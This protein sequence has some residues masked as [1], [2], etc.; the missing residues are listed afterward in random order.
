[1]IILFAVSIALT[2][3]GVPS[4][5][6][7]D[8]C[9][10]HGHHCLTPFLPRPVED[11]ETVRARFGPH[12]FTPP[13]DPQLNDT[14]DWYIWDLGGYPTATKKP[15]T[16]RGVGDHVYVVVEDSQWNVNIDQADVDRIVDHVDHISVGRFPNMGIWD[17]NTSNFGDPPNFD[18]LDRIFFLYYKFDISADGYFWIYDQYPDGSQP[19]ASNEADVIYLATDS[20]APAS[21]YM[22]AVGAHEFE[23]M[24]HFNTDQNE[25]SWVDEG[26]GE[27]AMW[28]F[29]HPDQISGFNTKPDNSL[30]NFGGNWGDYIQTYLW[31]LY[32]YEQFGG[33]PI[34]WEVCHNP[35]NGMAG[36]QQ[37]LV[38]QGYPDT[39]EDIFGNWSAANFLDEPEIYQGQYGYLGDELPNFTSF[40]THKSYPA[41]GTGSVQDWATDY[42]RLLDLNS[43]IPL[44]GF[45]GQDNHEFRVKLLAIDSV[46]PTLVKEMI[47]DAGSNGTVVF[48][49]AQA[50]EQVEISIASVTTFGT[51]SY[52]YSVDVEPMSIPVP[53]GRVAGPDQPVITQ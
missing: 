53:A 44:I 10:R 24:I 6:D 18:G 51:G 49:Q 4:F 16:V 15:C 22:L 45:D 21:D 38:N 28:L 33:Q 47:L 48:S 7:E 32:I 31:T 11:V 26:L 52:S 14:W 27:L 13:P 40:R 36:Y 42:V 30:I 43:G 23:H 35:A 3:L 46:K 20:G 17:L 41:N 34:I 8:R 9:H 39:M 37:S 25:N 12:E 1:M 5:A 2:V 29:G 50:Y 19:F